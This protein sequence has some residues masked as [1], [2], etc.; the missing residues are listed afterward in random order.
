MVAQ[1]PGMKFSDKLRYLMRLKGWNQVR[2]AEEMGT[3]SKS[4]VSN[5]MVERYKPDMDEIARL[6]RLFDVA[7]EFFLYP[8]VEEPKRSIYTE[9]QRMLIRV[10]D[11]IGI[12]AEEVVRRIYLAGGEPAKGTPEGSAPGQP[13]KTVATQD[14][15]ASRAAKKKKAR[16]SGQH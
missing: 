2:L 10:M 16:G 1:M 13:A 3:V 5:W 8:E 4:T 11:A 14:L 9:D 12:T 7:P 15:T 6:C